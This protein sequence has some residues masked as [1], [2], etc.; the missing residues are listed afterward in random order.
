M[1]SVLDPNPGTRTEAEWKRLLYGLVGSLSVHTGIRFVPISCIVADGPEY[2][3][4]QAGVDVRGCVNS[5]LQLEACAVVWISVNHGE[6]AWA[7]ATVLLYSDGRRVFGP[8]GN[9]IISIEYTPEGWR[10][11]GWRRGEGGEWEG[12]RTNARWTATEPN[13]AQPPA[14]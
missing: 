4:S 5:A 6:G 14:G 9:E 13:G 3:N 8:G 2:A 1:E 12:Y 11:H 10:D 7:G